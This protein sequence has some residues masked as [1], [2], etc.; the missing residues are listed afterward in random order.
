M[1]K[2]LLYCLFH[3]LLCMYHWDEIQLS[4]H[5]LNEQDNGKVNDR[6]CAKKSLQTQTE[7]T[8]FFGGVKPKLEIHRVCR[9][10]LN[11]IPSKEGGTA[12]NLIFLA[13]LKL[14]IDK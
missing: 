2:P 11:K 6:Y 5:S 12:Q 8:G 7:T 3:L 10:V 9:L 13:F 1:Y 4:S 14:N